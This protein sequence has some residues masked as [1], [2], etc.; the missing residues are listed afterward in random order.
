MASPLSAKEG[1]VSFVSFV[2][3][4]CC[5]DR[6]LRVVGVGCVLSHAVGGHEARWVS[7]N[8]GGILE[9]GGRHSVLLQQV[10]P[11]SDMSSFIDSYYIFLS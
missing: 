6:V 3:F 2:S 11:L 8:D 1:A 9:Q 10:Q 7:T 4:V 5:H